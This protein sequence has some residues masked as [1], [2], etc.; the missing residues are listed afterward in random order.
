MV[1]TLTTVFAGI[2]LVAT[3]AFAWTLGEY[4]MHRFA[5]HAMKGKGMASREHLTHHRFI[6]DDQHPHALHQRSMHH[7]SFRMMTHV[8][9][10]SPRAV[11]G[12]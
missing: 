12:R 11:M 8:R 4:L 1:H 6:V 7:G 9:Q 5:M 3:G 10:R 2:A